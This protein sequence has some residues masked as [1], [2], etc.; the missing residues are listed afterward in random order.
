[1]TRIAASIAVALVIAG[2]APARA[3]FSRLQWQYECLRDP[4]AV[5][6]DATPSGSD[7]LAPKAPP[8]ARNDTQASP[9]APAAA[10]PAGPSR[11]PAGQPPPPPPRRAPP[12]PARAPAPPPPA[13]TPTP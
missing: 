12:R 4:D 11:Q 6:F 2:I 3:D 10:L 9:D 7:P 5:C 1:M 13:P 8:A